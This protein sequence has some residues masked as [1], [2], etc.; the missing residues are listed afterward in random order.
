MVTQMKGL[1]NPQGASILV[2]IFGVHSLWGSQNGV[3]QKNFEN[4]VFQYPDKIGD[5]K[6]TDIK[7]SWNF[8]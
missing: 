5:R 3:F 6:K 2:A 8:I 1:V 7:N 4:M